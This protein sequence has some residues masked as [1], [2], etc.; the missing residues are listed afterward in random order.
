MQHSVD[1]AWAGH[2]DVSLDHCVCYML[3]FCFL[4]IGSTAWARTTDQEINSL[5]LYRLSYCGI[6]F[7]GTLGSRTLSAARHH[8]GI[9]N[10]VPYHPAHVP[11][12]YLAGDTCV[13]KFGGPYR[14]RT[15]DYALQGHCVPNY[16][17]SPNY[18]ASRQGVEPRPSVLET[19]MLP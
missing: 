4:K 11:S 7:G 10:P 12:K 13:L 5:L 18:L 2:C 1:Q 9:S 6:Y 19:D 14:G 8:R 15:G 17:N 16:T 3:T